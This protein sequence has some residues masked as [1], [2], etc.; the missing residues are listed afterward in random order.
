MFLSTKGKPYIMETF[1]YF[2]V[3]DVN[4]ALCMI[5]DVPSNESLAF[6]L[7]LFKV[8]SDGLREVSGGWVITI[9]SLNNIVF[10][11]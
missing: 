10:C 9:F 1:S 7:I 8:F 6:S 4:L 5:V 3:A 2:P 11:L